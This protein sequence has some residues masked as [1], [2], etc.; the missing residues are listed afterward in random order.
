MK[1][2]IYSIALL[3]SVP[4]ISPVP[5]DNLTLA[6]KLAGR[7]L[8]QPESNGEAW[9]VNPV[10]NRRYFLG[11]PQDAFD[12]M[13]KFG[14]GISNADLNKISPKVADE[15]ADSDGDGYNNSTEIKNGYDPHG[16]G[17]LN[18]DTDFTAKNLGKIFLQTE[19]NGEA[20]YINPTDQ[21]RYFLNRPAD[22][23]E[24]MRKLGLGITNAN[25]DTIP[26][27]VIPIAII[28][29]SQP[30]I[31]QPNNDTISAAANAF[32]SGNKAEVVKYF[33]PSM[34]KSIEVGMDYLSPEGR[35][36]L[37]NILSGS[38]LESS[39]ETKKIY[40]NEVYFNGEK[41]PVRFYVEK[42]NGVWLMT[43]L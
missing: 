36:T 39:T 28:T 9:Y 31:Q 14:A 38:R 34:K 13:K 43:N 41:I 29:P 27:A 35:L 26:V 10:D 21:K 40:L 22:A 1:K 19:K 33:I 37:G 4:L 30:P 25:I 20:W 17:K 16:P 3:T 23:F 42:I 2:F 24:I 12:L 11:R 8:L 5:L 32:R 6:S 18:I 7:I 15:L